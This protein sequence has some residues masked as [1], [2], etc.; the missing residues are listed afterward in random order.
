[1]ALVQARDDE[2]VVRQA[3]ALA[4]GVGADLLGLLLLAP[5]GEG[6]DEDFGFDVR[7]PLEVV[8]RGNARPRLPA[9]EGE[10]PGPRSGS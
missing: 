3:E 9:R 2:E 10:K 6:G 7:A 8:Y 1:V 5:A 4:D